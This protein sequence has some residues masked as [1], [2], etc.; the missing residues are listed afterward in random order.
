MVAPQKPTHTDQRDKWVHFVQAMNPEIDPESIRLMDSVRQTAHSLYLKGE[1][2]LLATGLSYAKYRV[3]MSLMI[4]EKLEG[5]GALNPSEISARQGTSRNTISSLIRDLEDEG[6]IE[7]RLDP[8]DRRKF[9]IQLT[10]AGREKVR[11]HAN[12]HFQEIAAC[13]DVLS[14]DEKEILG[15]LMDRLKQAARGDHVNDMEK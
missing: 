8:D 3:L 11:Q 10:D 6:L 14:N 13:F 5:R 9:N 4:S 12:N 7:R 1:N 15:A 2:S